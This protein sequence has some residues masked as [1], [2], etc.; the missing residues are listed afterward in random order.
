MTETPFCGIR[1]LTRPGEVMSPRTAT[2][3]LVDAAASGSALGRRW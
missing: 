3:A 1:V 2:E